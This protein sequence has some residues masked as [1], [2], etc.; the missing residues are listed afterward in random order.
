MNKIYFIAF[1][2]IL[3]SFQSMAMWDYL[4]TCVQ[5]WVGPEADDDDDGKD[6]L[7]DGWVEI[8]D[9]TE[10]IDNTLEELPPGIEFY[11]SDDENS[12]LEAQ[13]D[14]A[15]Y[16]LEE[17][18]DTEFTRYF[19]LHKILWES[20]ATY[21]KLWNAVVLEDQNML[22]IVSTHNFEF[23]AYA[24]INNS[25]LQIVINNSEAMPDYQL[26]ALIACE[27]TNIYQRERFYQID[28]Q[29]RAGYY[30]THYGE[31]EALRYAYEKEEIEN[32]MGKELHNMIIS[33]AI[34]SSNGLVTDSWRRF[35]KDFLKKTRYENWAKYL[36]DP[37]NQQHI[38]YYVQNYNNCIRPSLEP[39]HREAF[40]Q[41]V[42]KQAQRNFEPEG[43]YSKN[44]LGQWV[45][46]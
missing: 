42:I 2:M 15:A 39:M 40:M 10:V 18:K 24:D 45:K 9:S 27:L 6:P 4:P 46:Q 33:E 26:G 13:L 38:N 37:D 12:S 28:A 25:R 31:H 41:Q 5:N 7:D 1:I 22:R 20:S 43:E 35:H 8:I 23:E 32:I 3:S 17:T 21:K 29:A 36:S 14:F 19:E 11:Y 16:N 30:L 44:N 34:A